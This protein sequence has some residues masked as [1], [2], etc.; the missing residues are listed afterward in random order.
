MAFVG[1][2]A[3][4]AGNMISARLQLRRIPVVSAGAW[5]MAYGAALL[6]GFAAFRGQAFVID[7]HP[8]Y[9][10]ALAYLAIVATVVAFACYLTLLGRIGADRAAYVT[11]LAPVLALCVSTFAE[12]YRWNW[13][14]ALGLVAV[15]A[16]NLLV[17]RPA[18]A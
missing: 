18:R 1:T 3:F 8:V 9:L 17:L 7:P 4:C 14:A 2:L 13:I 11:V 10:G 6:A 16:G 15:L 12:G 5:G